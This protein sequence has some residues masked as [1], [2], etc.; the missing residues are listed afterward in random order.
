MHDYTE[1]GLLT[2]IPDPFSAGSVFK[3]DVSRRQILTYKDGP[4]TERISM[5]LT[6][7]YP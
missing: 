1:T 5:F 3:S 2:N 7:T 4:L 6:A